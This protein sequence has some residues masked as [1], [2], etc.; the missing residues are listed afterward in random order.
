MTGAL[1]MAMRG[2][3]AGNS[4]EAQNGGY[5]EQI[6]IR[7]KIKILTTHFGKIRDESGV[8][9]ERPYHELLLVCL[10]NTCLDQ[11]NACT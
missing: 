8:V 3:R 5:Q 1:A 6:N 10:V 2:Q 9:N 11:I 4:E 7:M